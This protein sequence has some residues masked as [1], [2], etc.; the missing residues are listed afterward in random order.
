MAALESFYLDLST[1]S[2]VVFEFSFSVSC[3][4]VYFKT[5]VGSQNNTYR[6]KKLDYVKMW[7]QITLI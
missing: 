1:V 6:K 2:V 7:L 5:T 4:Q 3:T